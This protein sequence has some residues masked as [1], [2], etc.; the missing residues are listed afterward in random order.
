MAKLFW[1]CLCV[2][3]LWM[4]HQVYALKVTKVAEWKVKGSHEG[5]RWSADGKRILYSHRSGKTRALSLFFLKTKASKQIAKGTLV[6]YPSFGPV[7]TVFA[8]PPKQPN[9][10]AVLFA[11]KKPKGKKS[12]KETD[13]CHVRDRDVGIWQKEHLVP[14]VETTILGDRS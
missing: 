12:P 7:G 14:W 2:C 9:W 6:F 11:S 13:T 4:P 5:A 1:V 3:V 8:G 10:K